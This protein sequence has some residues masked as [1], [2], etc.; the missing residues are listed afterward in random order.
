[1][2]RVEE[3]MEDYC[4][5]VLEILDLLKKYKV[6]IYSEHEEDGWVN[7]H[8]QTCGTIWETSDPKTVSQ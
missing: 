7:V 4:P 1:M 3:A 8:C 2:S 5:H 6:R